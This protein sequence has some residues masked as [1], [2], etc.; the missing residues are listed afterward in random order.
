[1]NELTLY[2]IQSKIQNLNNSGEYNRSIAL[3]ELAQSLAL[4]YGIEN[5]SVAHNIVI[6]HVNALIFLRE[7]DK[8]GKLLAGEIKDY[9]NLKDNNVLGSM[10][11][12][13]GRINKERG[14]YAQALLDLKKSFHY[15]LLIKYDV[16]CAQ[17]LNN[18]G[19]LVF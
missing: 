17:T 19:F 11:G 1:M 16:G 14:D 13:M 7:Y 8:A 10:Y 2:S 15:N 5:S 4:K 3:A 18:I 6:F 12:L 9:I